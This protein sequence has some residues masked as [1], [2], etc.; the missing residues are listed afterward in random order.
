[1]ATR[2][3]PP[4]TPAEHA[5]INTTRCCIEKSPPEK[6][7]MQSFVSKFN[8]MM[9]IQTKLTVDV[10]FVE[11]AMVVAMSSSVTPEPEY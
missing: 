9:W 6:P 5:T 4:S 10:T 3:V 1:M 7:R 2:T 11:T 8:H